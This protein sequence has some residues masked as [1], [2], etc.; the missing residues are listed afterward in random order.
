VLFFLDV[1]K[2]FAAN[3]DVNAG[4]MPVLIK[5]IAQ[6]RYGDDQSAKR[7]HNNIIACHELPSVVVGPVN[8]RVREKFLCGVVPV[9][10]APRSG[11]NFA[12]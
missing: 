6:H 2:L 12:S 5:L 4:F 3:L 9:A 10:S 8:S 1:Q 7:Q 11:D